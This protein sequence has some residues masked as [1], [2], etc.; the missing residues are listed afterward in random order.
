M[1]ENKQQTIT[2]SLTPAHAHCERLIPQFP[3]GEFQEDILQIAG[4][5][6]EA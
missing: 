2:N 6:Y 5:V 4:A 3:P 1:A